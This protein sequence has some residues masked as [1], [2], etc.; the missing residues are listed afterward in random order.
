MTLRDILYTSLI[1]GAVGLSGC[2]NSNNDYNSDPRP[3][4]SK[5]KIEE[6]TEPVNKYQFDS[7]GQIDDLWGNI[8]QIKVADLDGDGDLD[9][10]VG[11]DNGYLLIYENNLPQ[12]RVVGE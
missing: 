7:F 10:I 6:S 8:R 1:A 4:D 3:G 12:K 2:G 11:N 5:V 9:I